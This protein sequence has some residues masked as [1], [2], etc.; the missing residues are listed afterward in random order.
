MVQ[1]GGIVNI[2]NH[3]KI[4]DMKFELPPHTPPGRHRSGETRYP[5]PSEILDR[6]ALIGHFV[7]AT[8]CFLGAV[9]LLNSNR[10]QA[11]FLVL[12]GAKVALDGQHFGKY[13]DIL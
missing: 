7:C 8:G 10:W 3:D 6:A 1:V 11:A 13:S 5:T 9:D 4:P 12:A 2:T